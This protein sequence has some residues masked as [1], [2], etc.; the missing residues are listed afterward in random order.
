MPP[1]LNV[2][3][4]LILIL[5]ELGQMDTAAS[6]CPHALST[7]SENYKT[8][9]GLGDLFNS[10]G[11]PEEAVVLYEKTLAIKPESGPA[12][13][14]L[15]NVL[16]AIDRLDE[17]IA[18]YQKALPL[19]PGNAELYY[20]LGNAFRKKQMFDDA[21]SNYEKALV[22]KPHHAQAYFNMGNV[23]KAMGQFKTAIGC[24]ERCIQINSEDVDAY[25]NLANARYADGQMQAAVSTY[26]ETLR[27]KP[28]HVMALN[29]LGCLS[30][31]LGADEQAVAV[32]N[33]S[34]EIDPTY[35]P[36]YINLGNFYKDCNDFEHAYAAYQK[37]ISLEPEN[38]DALVCM[39]S[40]LKKEGRFQEGV[41]FLKRAVAACPD[42]SRA[43]WYY[44]LALP[45]LYETESE[46]D[47]F[48]ERFSKGLAI[49]TDSVTLETPGQRKRALE[50][51]GSITNF[52]LQYQ[53]RDDLELQKRYGRFVHRVMAANFP[54]WVVSRPMPPHEKGTRIKIGYL[55]SF[56]RSHTVGHF[57][58]GWLENHDRMNFE[59][60]C[61]HIGR[62]T[63]SLTESFKHQCDRFYHIAG[64]IEAVARQILDDELHILIYTDIGMFAPATQL[65]GLR[66]APIQCKGW[67]H[68]VTTGLP[69][70]DYYL[71][72]DL[73]EA[74]DAATHYSET[75]VRLPNLA[76]ALN[77]PQLSENEILREEFGISDGD[78]VFLTSQ[79]LFKYLPQYDDIYPRIAAMVKNA[80]FVFI[81]NP[82]SG[83]TARF[84]KRIENAFNRHNLSMDHFCVFQPR[85]SSNGFIRLNQA[86]NVL[87]DPFSW[88][89]GKT[90]FEGISCGLPVV[91]CPGR[92]M[93][94][95]HAYA[96]LKMMGITETIAEDAETYIAI[97]CRLGNDSEFYDRIRNATA[98]NRQRLLNDET[99]VRELEDFYR[100][101]VSASE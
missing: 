68:P 33:R 93:R 20:N 30:R 84:R 69:T 64:N 77:A 91:T 57:L 75:L 22:L 50:G 11:Y 37:A 12:L 76:L 74:E 44:H 81:S 94:G 62:L 89:G 13:S 40:L 2:V 38:Q 34:I 59:V 79:S 21:V 83:L 19:D 9:Q 36:A 56:M 10:H 85:L 65:A 60:H 67:G 43:W 5:K 29:N 48:R 101:V 24:Y 54:Q 61:Y 97:A 41:D 42:I 88:S 99:C 51:I 45:I 16:Q 98:A 46:I 72:S 52:Y 73:M 14:N 6:Y 55:S 26:E 58:M 25:Y 78:F 1:D 35:T 80:R 32:F 3:K 15:G 71:S 87:L 95:R 27:R 96:M 53:G 23:F 66:L 47:H 70:I 49:L 39:G 18:C 100:R 8:Y 92:F 4:N 28:D 82:S 7:S 17:S 63:D 90:T 86:S 31:D